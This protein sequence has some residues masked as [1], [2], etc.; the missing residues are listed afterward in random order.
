MYKNSNHTQ[1]AQF[2]ISSPEFRVKTGLYKS[3]AAIY[4]Y[5]IYIFLDYLLYELTHISDLTVQPNSE[6]AI[7]NPSHNFMPKEL[8]N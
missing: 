4:I 8:F 3:A 2:G 6:S 7:L 1:T 5:F